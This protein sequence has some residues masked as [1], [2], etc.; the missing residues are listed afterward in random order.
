MKKFLLRQRDDRAVSAHL[1][2][3]SHV[4]E[5]STA[6]PGFEL[7]TSIHPRLPGTAD[8]SSIYFVVLVFKAAP[9]PLPQMASQRPKVLEFAIMAP[10]LLEASDSWPVLSVTSA[11]RVSVTSNAL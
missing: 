11:N 8:D 5:H 6:R 3:S 10:H 4:E 2:G 7:R 9:L 1:L